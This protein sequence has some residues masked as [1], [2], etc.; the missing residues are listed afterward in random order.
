MLRVRLIHVK[1]KGDYSTDFPKQS[2]CMR[3]KEWRCSARVTPARSPW[4]AHKNTDLIRLQ[5]G[6]RDCHK[7]MVLHQETP[8]LA[9]RARK[10][11]KMHTVQIY[12]Q[13]HERSP[14]AD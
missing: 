9:I 4:L 5:Q 2:V 12:E 7:A 11:K 14:G 1:T 10:A 6:C 3:S 8:P 13:A